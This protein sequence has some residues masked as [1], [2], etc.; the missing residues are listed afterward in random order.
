VDVEHLKLI[1]DID[2]ENQTTC[3][4]CGSVLCCRYL[5]RLNCL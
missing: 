3:E 5:F 2:L 1:Y 4:F